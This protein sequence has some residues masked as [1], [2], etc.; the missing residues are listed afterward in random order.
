M[1]IPGITGLSRVAVTTTET[2]AST[3]PARMS[4]PVPEVAIDE[5][6]QQPLPPRFPWLSRL[7]Q[8]LEQAALQKPAFAP[9][10]ILGDN[11]DR[12]V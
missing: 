1:S 8:Q 12:S 2:P 3:P 5:V 11:I 4:N 7:S 10:P 9:A 6:T